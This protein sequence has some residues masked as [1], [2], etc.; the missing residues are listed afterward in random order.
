M[1]LR[2]DSKRIVD[3]SKN[4]KILTV[5]TRARPKSATSARSAICSKM[6]SNQKTTCRYVVA[7]IGPDQKVP[8]V[9]VNPNILQMA[10]FQNED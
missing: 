10:T 3:E 6:P 4:R 8:P 7:Q 1:A 9:V 5:L 2:V